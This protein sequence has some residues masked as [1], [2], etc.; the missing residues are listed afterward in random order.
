MPLRKT[1]SIERSKCKHHSSTSI[2][3]PLQSEKICKGTHPQDHEYISTKFIEKS[4]LSKAKT[5]EYMEQTKRHKK[6]HKAIA[7]LIK[8]KKCGEGHSTH[9]CTKPK[10][11]PPKCANCNGEHLTTYIKCPAN[12]NN[13]AVNKKFIDAPPP[14]TKPP[15]ELTEQVA[16]PTGIRQGHGVSP[17]LLNLI[18]DKTINSVKEIAGGYRIEQES[19][20]L[21]CYA[22]DPILMSVNKDD[23]QRL[24]YRFQRKTGSLKMG[25]AESMVI[26]IE[27]IRYI[28]FVNDESNRDYM[29]CT[30][31]GVEIT[32]S[33]KPQQEVRAQIN[34]ASRIS[35]YLRDL[36]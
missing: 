5:D 35:G 22:D 30:Y 32:S 11:T 16:A 1:Q 33:K 34:K 4:E 24:L 29:Q 12:P 10:A 8:C 19:M 31:L 20:K 15:H 27:P 36:I 3:I 18:I 26:A 23:L 17:V 9:L 2:P 14:K 6:R 21:L 25:K 7:T 13:A 28:L